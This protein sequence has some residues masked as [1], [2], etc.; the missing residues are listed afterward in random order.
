MAH[1]FESGFF[2]REPAWHK[3]GIV[4]D[5]PPTIE[6]AIIQAGLNWEVVKKPL[7]LG[8]GQEI[9]DKVAI[10][11][12]SDNSYLGTVGINYEPV[13]NIEAFKWFQPFIDEGALSLETALSLRNGKRVCVLG[14]WNREG[15]VIEG[16]RIKSY[17][18][19]STAHDGSMAVHCQLTD[20]RVVCMNTFK[21]ALRAAENG[22]EQAL[23]VRH[24]KNVKLGLEAVRN[25]IDYV[26]GEFELTLQQYR[27]LQRQKLPINGLENYVK[28]VIGIEDF[29]TKKTGE[30]K[31]PKVFEITKE[32]YERG[33]GSDIPGVRGNYW[34]A[35]NAVTEWVDHYRG[36]DAELRLE[37]MLLGHGAELKTKAFNVALAHCN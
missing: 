27:K 4:L 28:E 19:F 13:Q 23:K 24:T 16:D 36:R 12:N 22:S 1:E 30:D 9:D 20:I 25:C 34:G 14:K 7:F 17:L 31:K 5:E 35:F 11:R 29:K 15:E 37:N 21:L 32:L 18:L 2:V 33:L 6:D 8:N 10:V 26:N 3:L